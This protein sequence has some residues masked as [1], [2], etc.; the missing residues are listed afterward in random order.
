MIIVDPHDEEATEAQLRQQ[1]ITNA[2][3]ADPSHKQ[4]ASCSYGSSYSH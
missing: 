1:L 4:E 2:Q 3:S